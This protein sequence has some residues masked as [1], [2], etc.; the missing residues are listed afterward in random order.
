VDGQITN[1]KIAKEMGGGVRASYTKGVRNTRKGVVR[2]RGKKQE[3]DIRSKS[4]GDGP[5]Q[6]G[7]NIV[8]DAP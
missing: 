5:Q 6:Q 4:A 3:E 1:Q 8:L 2:N 7:Q